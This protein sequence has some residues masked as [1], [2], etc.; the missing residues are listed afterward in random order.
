MNIMNYSN[1]SVFRTALVRSSSDVNG[2]GRTTLAV[3]LLR[4]TGAITQITA[5]HY[6]NGGNLAVGSTATLYGIA[7]A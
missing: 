5:F 6:G 2:A 4:G 3:S 1:T 7:A